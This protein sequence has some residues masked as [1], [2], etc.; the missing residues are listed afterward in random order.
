MKN[1]TRIR[2]EGEAHLSVLQFVT[3][4][5]Q[6]RFGDSLVD[7]FHEAGPGDDQRGCDSQ[8]QDHS[9][10]AREPEGCFF[11]WYCPRIAC[12]ASKWYRAQDSRANHLK[13]SSMSQRASSPGPG[14]FEVPLCREISI[15]PDYMMIFPATQ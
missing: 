5:G 4:F 11:Q 14:G 2:E 10:D 3:R 13:D 6:E 12:A 9:Q 8:H 15:F 1:D 7:M